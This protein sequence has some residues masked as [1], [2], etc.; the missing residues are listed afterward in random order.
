MK[1]VA[2]TSL[3]AVDRPNADRPNAARSRQK[4]GVFSGHYVIA[5]SLPPERWPLERRTLVPIFLYF[6]TP[7]LKYRSSLLALP[8]LLSNSGKVNL[9][10]PTAALVLLPGSGKHFVVVVVVVVVLCY[11]SVIE[12]PKIFQIFAELCSLSDWESLNIL[13]GEGHGGQTG[14]TWKS[15]SLA[16]TTRLLLGF[17]LQVASKSITCFCKFSGYVNFWVVIYIQGIILC[18]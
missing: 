18:A 10:F 7:C 12:N 1:I 3:P 2:T 17:P 9:G 11:T 14:R 8:V 4:N 5:S 6:K 15:Y 13:W 16:I